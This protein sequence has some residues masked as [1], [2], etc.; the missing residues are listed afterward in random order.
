ME[1]ADIIYDGSAN[2]H[3]NRLESTQRQA[4]IACTDAYKHTNHEDLLQDLGWTALSLRRKHHRLNLM[5]KI[6]NQLTPNYLREACPVLTRERTTYNLRT[7]MNISTPQM[8]TTT[9][10][11]SYFLKDWNNLNTVIRS[12]PSID[13]FKDNLKKQTKAKVNPLYHHNSN[14]ADINQTRMRLGLSGLGSHRFNY[15]HIADPKCMT[16]GAK[17]EDPSH[18]FLTCQ[19]YDIP[20]PPFLEGICEI[21]FANNV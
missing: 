3:L 16:C 8:R 5:Y 19:T 4:A 18:F 12:A 17:I 14:K 7:G 11:M 2:T 10:Q 15:K 6:Q 1:Y 13:A 21:L 9:Y 20:R